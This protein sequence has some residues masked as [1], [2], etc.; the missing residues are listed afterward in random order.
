MGRFL[1]AVLELVDQVR[2]ASFI[3]LAM[4]KNPPNP[5]T[6]RLQVSHQSFAQCPS[7]PVRLRERWD[8]QKSL[9][10]REG[11]QP[12]LFAWDSS[13]SSMENLTYLANI[14]SPCGHRDVSKPEALHLPFSPASNLI[15]QK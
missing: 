11:D 8:Q 5:T 14:W 3:S 15:R 6:S 12:Y 1:W 2:M 13:S 7:P 10:S 9:R 4:F